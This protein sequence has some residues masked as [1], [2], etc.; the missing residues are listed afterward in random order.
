MKL[1]NRLQMIASKIE[2]GSTVVDIGTDHAYLPIYL[3]NE[4]ISQKVIAT[5]ILSGPYEKAR[6]N[7]RKSGHQDFI[8]LRFGSGLKPIK[9]GEGDIAVAAGMGAISIINII[10]ESRETA[11]SFKKIILQPMRNQAKLREYLFTIGYQIIDEDVAME[12]KKFYEIIVAKR[13]NLKRFDEIDILV[14]PVL[15]YKRISVV[16]EYINHRIR[17]LQKVIESLKNTNSRAGKI[18]LLE[19]ERQIKALK[20][21][22]K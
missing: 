4:G 14:G 8:D 5:E 17:I 15:R 20:E 11:D 2:K 18:A 22:I 7:I 3:V 16:Y 1:G 19:C 9:P 13:A 12:A 21:A 10:D 6:E